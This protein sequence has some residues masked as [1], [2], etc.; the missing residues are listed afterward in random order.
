MN[1]LWAIH[2]HLGR[3]PDQM[4]WGNNTIL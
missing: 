1:E 3:A 4:R 2:R